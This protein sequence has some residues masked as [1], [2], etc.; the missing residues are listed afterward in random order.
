[1][2][3]V[4]VDFDQEKVSVDEVKQLV[5]GLHEVVSGTTNIEDVP[6][7]ANAS[8]FSYAIAP[9]EVFIEL[10]EHKVKDAGELTQILK[11]NLAVWM[12]NNEFQHPINMT[13]IPMKW[14]IEIEIKK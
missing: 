3:V 14:N 4:R 5:K 8:Q 2:P 1:M 12:Q 11:Q 6:V 13:F 9:I 7:Y 10:S